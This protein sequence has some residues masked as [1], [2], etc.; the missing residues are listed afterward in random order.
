MG[1]PFAYGNQQEVCSRSAIEGEIQQRVRSLRKIGNDRIHLA[2]RLAEN[3]TLQRL[4]SR[5]RQRPGS[6]AGRSDSQDLKFG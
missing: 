5:S 6:L 3:R 1:S 4:I 2:A